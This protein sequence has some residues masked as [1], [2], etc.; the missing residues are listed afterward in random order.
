MKDDNYKFYIKYKGE[1]IDIHN[2]CGY[3]K[4]VINNHTVVDTQLF[5][6]KKFIDDYYRIYENEIENI[7]QRRPSERIYNFFI[8]ILKQNKKKKNTQ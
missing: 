6:I 1:D 8:E 3:F 4:V 2:T 7:I 5:K